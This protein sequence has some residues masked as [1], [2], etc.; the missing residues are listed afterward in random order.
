FLGDVR[1]FN[2]EKEGF[3][4]NLQVETPY[5]YEAGKKVKISV[6]TFIGDVKVMKVG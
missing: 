3:M 6:S 2:Q 5:Y 1:V 4:N